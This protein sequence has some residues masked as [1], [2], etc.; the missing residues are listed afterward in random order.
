[1]IVLRQNVFFK[2]FI[3]VLQKN[4]AYK[5]VLLSDHILPTTIMMKLLANYL[6]KVAIQKTYILRLIDLKYR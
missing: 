1:M 5:T 4:T 3:S 2:R 6:D